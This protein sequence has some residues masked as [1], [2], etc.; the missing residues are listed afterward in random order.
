MVVLFLIFL[1]NLHIVFHSD[2][3]S[4]DSH[5]QCINVAFFLHILTNIC[6]LSYFYF[7]NI[8]WFFKTTK[9]T[10]RKG[11]WVAVFLLIF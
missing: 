1:R 10:S 4:L 11:V 7:V 6:Y 2:Y 8:L 9:T 3:I 5:Q